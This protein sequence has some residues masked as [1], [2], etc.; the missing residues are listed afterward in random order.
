MTESRVID[1]MGRFDSFVRAIEHDGTAASVRLAYRAH[2]YDRDP[3]MYE[4]FVG[5]PDQMPDA[6]LERLAELLPGARDS[7]LEYTS[8]AREEI[9][10]STRAAERIFDASLAGVPQYVTINLMRSNAQVRFLDEGLAIVYGMDTWA[11][12]EG[13]LLAN[14]PRSLAV[15]V[16][17]ELFHAHHWSMNPFMARWAPRFLPPHADAPLW[18]NLWSEG[19]ASCAAR[20]V[21]PN[22]DIALVMGLEGVWEEA[23]DRMSNLA[24][25]L[26]GALDSTDPDIAARWL[27]LQLPDRNDGLPNKAGY[28]VGL[29]AAHRIVLDE[30]LESATTLAGGPLRAAF[31]NAVAALASGE[32]PPR[33]ADVCRPRHRNDDP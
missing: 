3:G 29:A 13:R 11:V 17:H 32:P 9:P 8:L 12:T 14:T 6:L 33:A 23:E 5:D 27:F 30:D 20:Q 28:S 1:H 22:A 25:A 2:F 10:D 19:L 18:I 15:T 7:I 24:Q 4:A 21:Y 16:A 26:L 31:R